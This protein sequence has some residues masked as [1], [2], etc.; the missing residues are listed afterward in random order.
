MSKYKLIFVSFLF[1]GFCFGQIQKIE[2][3]AAYG[4]PSLFGVTYEIASTIVGIIGQDSDF[5]RSKGVLDLTANLYSPNQRWRYG[6][7]LT[8]EFFEYS[9]SVSRANFLS[10]LPQIDYMWLNP[11]RKFNIY[12]GL[13]AGITFADKTYNTTEGPRRDNSSGFGFSVTPIGLRYG[14]NFG[15][16]FETNLG[17]KSLAQLGLFYK[18]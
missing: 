1:S 15:G 11:T 17:M 2:F 10:I 6:I 18:F 14:G 9:T 7:G 8:N 4:S 12:S 5:A 13:A 3:T 16:F